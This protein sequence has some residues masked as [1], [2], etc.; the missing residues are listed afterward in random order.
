M[1]KILLS[2][3]KAE[4][5][6]LEMMV[7]GFFYASISL[8]LSL[9]ILPEYSSMVMIFFT[10]V[11]CL[12]VVQKAVIAEEERESD[13]GSEKK[14]L[15]Y[16]ARTLYFLVF[17]FIGFVFAF[18][19]WTIILPYEQVSILFNLQSSAIQEIKTLTGDATSNS[20]LS[21]ILLNNLKIVLISFLLALFYGAGAI[22][23][24]VW[25]ASVMG[26]II[27]DLA[28]NTFGLT[29]LPAIIAKYFLHG[30]PEM[31][32]YF[33]ATLAG[34]ILFISFVRGD[35]FEKPKKILFGAS[36]LFVASLLLLIL[37]AL[38]EVY[39]SPLV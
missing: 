29:A 12:Y 2:L 30:I 11:S 34:G 22:F 3:K 31:L 25:N 21:A 38:I 18:A 39:I 17:L 5:H 20:G 36:L 6:P 33:T 1:L 35:I 27:G 28:R 4:N 19:L 15:T 13:I 16:H 9:W 26:F 32:A 23:I 14:I 24:L 7:V 10:V 37:A 8:I